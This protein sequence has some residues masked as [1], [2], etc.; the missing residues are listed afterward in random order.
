MTD[1][2]SSP[3]PGQPVRIGPW[4][5]LNERSS[6]AVRVSSVGASPKTLGGD[7]GATAQLALADSR[8][9]TLLTSNAVGATRSTGL[10]MVHGNLGTVA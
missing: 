10:M 1:S 8:W 9:G 6:L 7:R 5:Q 3:L 4:L 2:G